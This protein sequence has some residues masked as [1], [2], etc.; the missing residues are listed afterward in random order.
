M[1]PGDLLGLTV[2][3][4]YAYAA[5]AISDTSLCR[6]DRARLTEVAD[7]FPALEHRMLDLASNELVQAQEHLLVLGRKTA[8]ERVATILFRLLERIGRQSDGGGVVDLPMSRQDIGDYAGLTIE[9]VSRVISKLR[10][11]GALSTSSARH[12]EVPDTELL[13]QL[14]GDY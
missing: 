8:T 13:L 5:D 4:E 11:E 9:T 6:F 12:I 1:F 2:S 7:R 10:N 14:S 3:G